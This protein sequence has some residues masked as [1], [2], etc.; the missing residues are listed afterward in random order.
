MTLISAQIE[1]QTIRSIGC[2][3]FAK[4]RLSSSIK[5]DRYCSHRIS[6]S[7][8]ITLYSLTIE[9]HVFSIL[10]FR[11]SLNIYTNIRPNSQNVWV[12][13]QL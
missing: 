7:F 3:T 9:I 11:Y 13:Y 8:C 12:C 1:F 10:F 5:A 2:L 6:E 4:K